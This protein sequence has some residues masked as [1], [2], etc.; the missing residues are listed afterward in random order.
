MAP[1]DSLESS[2]KAAISVMIVD[3]SSNDA[4]PVSHLIEQ[5]DE[6][7]LVTHAI[8]VQSAIELLHQQPADCL[9]VDYSV[10]TEQSTAL[11]HH[12]MDA[13]HS[14]TAL[15]VMISENPS[16]EIHM[17]DGLNPSFLIKEHLSAFGAN[18]AVQQAIYQ[19]SQRCQLAMLREE[20]AKFMRI[21]THD[22]RG[23]NLCQSGTEG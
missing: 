19:T 3:G 7:Y 23:T 6:N 20:Q 1:T 9:I 10:F 11:S 18:L 22:L 12:L 2:T 21:L 13:Q 17:A 15:L 16:L 14:S 8:D 4:N 5:S